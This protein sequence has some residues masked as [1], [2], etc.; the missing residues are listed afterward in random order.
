M[1]AIWIQKKIQLGNR[2]K[3]V[4][5][6]GDAVSGRLGEIGQDHICV[7]VEDSQDPAVIPVEMV[8]YFQPL[9]NEQTDSQVSKPNRTIA[10]NSGTGPCH[11]DRMDGEISVDTILDDLV[12]RDV[13]ECDRGQ[14]YRIRVGLFNEWLIVNG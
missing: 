9:A 8:S 14:Y 10:D 6:G 2:A 12:K 3:F 1:N 11:R 13:V 5:K 7:E 4:L